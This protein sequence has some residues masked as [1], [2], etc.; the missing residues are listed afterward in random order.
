MWNLTA[1]FRMFA[2]GHRG[3]PIAAFSVWRHP[4][5]RRGVIPCVFVTVDTPNGAQQTTYSQAEFAA[6]FTA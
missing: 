5:Q 1:F 6:R 2:L 4:D 3:Y